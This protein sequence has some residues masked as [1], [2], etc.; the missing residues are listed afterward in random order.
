MTVDKE[1]KRGLFIVIE[2]IDGCG[3]D[4][5]LSLLADYLSSRGYSVHK[6]TEPTDGPIGR[7]IRHSGLSGK[8]KL[9]NLEMQ[10]LFSMDR[11]YHISNEIEP[12]LKEG[13]I[14]ISG[15]YSLS[16]LAYGYAAGSDMEILEMANEGFMSPDLVLYID[17][18]A[19]TAMERL[20]KRGGVKEVYEKLDFLKKAGEGYKR[21]L[22][23]FNT[24]T[25]DGLLSQ[26][27]AHKR[28]VSAVSKYL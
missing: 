13:K 21:V 22:P 18:D 16:T 24:E 3:K 14:V 5:Q 15:R 27:D 12:A 26:E 9:T 7:V 4:T 11:A 19:D 10:L 25:I 17:L 1:K 6:T 23:K 8:K 20:G 2:G 28:I